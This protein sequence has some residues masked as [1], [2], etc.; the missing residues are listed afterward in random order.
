VRAALYC[1]IS[2]DATGQALGVTRQQQDGEDLAKNLGWEIV[3][4][5]VDNDIS[6]T[7]GKVRP[8]YRKM[9]ADAD[10]GHIEAII[11]WHA[12]R[13]Y[14][15]AVDLGELV[16]V[17]KRNNVQIATVRAGSIDLTTPTGRLIAG[18]LAQVATYEG[19]AKADRWKRSVRQRREAG[20][21]APSGPRMYGYTR[22]GEII[23]EEAEQIRWMVSE[24]NKGTSL[25]GL[26]RECHKRGMA[27]STGRPFQVQ[28]IKVLV[29]N[30]KLVGMATLNGDVIG[31]GQWE[32]ILESDEWETACAVLAAAPKRGVLP[33]VALL[34]GLIWCGKCE[35][36]MVTG[37]RV[38]RAGG[39]SRTY[40]CTRLPGAESCMSVSGSA[41]AIE[42]IVEA[43]TRRRL[44]DP[45]V[46]SGIARL[47]AQPPAVLVEIGEVEARILELEAS[48]DEP[49]VP[50]ATI[51]RA[52][53]RAKERLAELQ[54]R[55]GTMARTTLPARGEWPD[56][57]ARRRA[58]VD[59]V[60]ERVWLDPNRPEFTRRNEFD[61]E[62]V[63][64]DPR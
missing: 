50:V 51:L 29:A 2:L 52:V 12:D 4:V 27:S 59:L 10:A 41:D 26:A 43:Y 28:S 11:A 46:R 19:E 3:E 6:A 48:L 62:R 25:I 23:P 63:R 1:R 37:S 30:P 22:D 40:R 18:L 42:E 8:A 13:L 36:K 44:D 14:R 60:V 45:R 56:D 15:K 24:I 39:L 53:D 38:R 54:G 20:T 17:C 31:V 5:Y 55:L 35:T 34:P 9:L 64:I 49:G 57:L 61:P 33:R 7:S 32:P 47:S 21:F 16:D 58:L